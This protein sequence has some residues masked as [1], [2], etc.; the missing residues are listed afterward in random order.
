MAPLAAGILRRARGVPNGRRPPSAERFG[1]A[2]LAAVGVAAEIEVY[3]DGCG[4]IVKL[5]T[6]SEQY[7]EE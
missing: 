4:L 3:T 2:D 6:V 7:L 5:G 1:Q